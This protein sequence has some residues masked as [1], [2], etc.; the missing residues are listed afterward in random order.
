MSVPVATSS[1][2]FVRFAFVLTRVACPNMDRQTSS[3]KD[4]I[5][6]FVREVEWTNLP[7]P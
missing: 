1:S 4:E 3:Y 2:P 6:D 5:L 7:E